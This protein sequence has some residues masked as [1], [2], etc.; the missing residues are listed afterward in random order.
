MKMADMFPSKFLKAAELDGNLTL[1]IKTVL[2]EDL[3]EQ[4][5]PVAYF[6]ETKKG[7]VINR[8]NAN[9]ISALHGQDTDAWAGNQITLFATEVDFKGQ[10]TLAI[11]VR[12]SVPASP[13]PPPTMG[14]SKDQI[15]ELMEAGLALKHGL[16]PGDSEGEA[17]LVA[18]RSALK[19]AASTRPG[20]AEELLEAIRK[21]LSDLDEIINGSSN[22]M[23]TISSDPPFDDDVP[24]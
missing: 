20:T 13:A 5:K 11:R 4:L 7:L 6:L 16:G 15:R 24:F 8:T 21:K 9:T 12:L 1:T 18:T 19:S 10:T 2:Q 3:G 22:T 23:N 17:L 14:L